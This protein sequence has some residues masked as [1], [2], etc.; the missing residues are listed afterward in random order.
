MIT[1]KKY[2]FEPGAMSIVQMGEELIGHPST[3]LSELVKN[4][5]DADSLT[6]KVYIHLD[7]NEKRSFLFVHDDGLGMNKNVLFGEW[8]QPSMSSKRMGNGKSK[9][10]KRPLLGSKGIGR[11]AS[12]ALGKN[13]TVISKTIDEKEYNWIAIN[14]EIFRRETLLSDITFP[15]GTIKDLHNIF[16]DKDFLQDRRL[17]KNDSL[18]NILDSESLSSFNE[19]TLVV[20]EILDDSLQSVTKYT[21][22]PDEI[23]F[24]ET[25]IMFSLRSLVTPLVM[26]NSSQNDLLENKIIDHEF[27]TKNPKDNFELCFGSNIKIDLEEQNKK[28]IFMPVDP[29]PILD[30]YDYRV[31]GK[32][33]GEGNVKGHYFCKRL[34]EDNFDEPLNLNKDYVFSSEN[35]RKRRGEEEEEIPLEIKDAKLGEFYFDIRIYDRDP[36]S[37]DKLNELLKRPGK[38]F[39]RRLINNI[40]GFRISKNGFGVKPYGEENKDWMDL[41]QMRVQDPTTILSPNQLLGYIFLLNENNKSSNIGLSEK[42]N[43]E[44]FFENRAF[45]TLKEII[46]AILIEVGRKRFSYRLKHGLGR[47]IRNTLKRPD[48]K[49]YLTFIEKSTDDKKIRTRSEK[50][51]QEVT[52]ALDGMEKTLSFSQRLSTLGSGLELVYHE[53]TQPLT[54]IGGIGYSLELKAKDVIPDELRKKIVEDINNLYA[55]GKTIELLKESLRPAIGLSRKKSFK[56]FET[57]HKVIFLF[58]KDIHDFNITFNYRPS[59]SL[60]DYEIKDYEYA[61]W[62]AFLNIINNAVYWLKQKKGDHQ[63]NFSLERGEYLVIENNGPLIKEDLLDLIFEYGITDK[64]EKNATGLGLAFTRNILNAH[65]WEV[66]AENRD[67]GPAFLLRKVEK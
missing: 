17:E 28:T 21:E 23:A 24:Q 9:V 66:T 45:I 4:S 1:N 12:M 35:L 40:L 62:I 65:G 59:K 14:R 44:G 63:I 20:I 15:G 60:P 6:C 8:L 18:I 13:L 7:V 33:D 67:E 36:D 32:V 3:A 11:L 52:T 37:N 26:M 49:S 57:F 39:T 53:L 42:T 27:Y 54:Q 22:E 46:R 2:R 50:F 34:N 51:V 48:T 31:I 47:I 43:R 61:L 64:K 55:S 38:L 41:G 16:I 5:Y 19:G 30:K 10:F 56:P 25:G 29:L 58:T